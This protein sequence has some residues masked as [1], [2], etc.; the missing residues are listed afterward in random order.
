MGLFSIFSKNKQ[1]STAQD[2]GR[3]SRDDEDFGERARAK[4]ASYANESG[5][6]GSRRSRSGGDPM[7]PEKKRARRRLVGAVAL[8]LAA[9]VGLPMLLDSEPRPL[10]G[11]IAIQ[12][13]SKEKAPPLPM[14]A[15]PVPAAD[16]VDQGEEII[17][18]AS[19]S[20]PVAAAPRVAEP[21]PLK[22][23]DEAPAKPVAPVPKPEPKVAEHKPEP[24][25]VEHKAEP[26]PA[27]RKLAERPVE[28]P[29]VKKP[30]EK[31]V[32]LK[33]KDS[34][35][36]RALALL[37]GKPAAKAAEP[38][39]R[40]EDKADAQ[41]RFVVQVAALA[42]QE[43]VDELQARLRAGGISSFTKKSGSLIKVQVG[44]FGSREEADKTKAK[45]G[46]LGLAG[47][48]VPV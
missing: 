34:E 38:H 1:D 17:A 12:I 10:N 47:F 32:T 36:A 2:S 7:L 25:P 24:K 39:P 11:D 45:L 28:K 3:F 18:P 15:N 37:E 23:L 42:T 30:E 48:L 26:K 41:Q 4:R 29:A 40:A 31:P 5:Q 46:S 8:A 9:A 33:P 21:P 6:G 20:A 43:K 19:P 44:P 35:A 14:P 16:S 27:E 22:M 13:P